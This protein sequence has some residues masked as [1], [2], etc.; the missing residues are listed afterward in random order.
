MPLEDHC[1]D[2][3]FCKFYTR[4]QCFDKR[5][6]DTDIDRLTVQC[7]VLCGL[8]GNYTG[9]Y[10]DM[11]NNTSLRLN[12]E[13]LLRCITRPPQPRFG[14]TWFHNGKLLDT[15]TD[16]VELHVTEQSL[17]EYFCGRSN[18]KYSRVVD[19]MSLSCCAYAQQNCSRICVSKREK[20]WKIHEIPNST[21]NCCAKGFASRLSVTLLISACVFVLI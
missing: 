12:D 5:Y 8:C 15:S 3:S 13:V 11:F 6:I 9:S 4:K 1:V 7:P 16:F 20:Q 18:S 14:Y 2:E 10:I 19:V 21:D 17:G